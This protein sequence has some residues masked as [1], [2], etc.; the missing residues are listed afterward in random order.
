MQ[1]ST[2]LLQQ[3]RKEKIFTLMIEG[4]MSSLYSHE[5][6]MNQRINFTHFKQALQSKTSTRGRGGQQGGRSH[7]RGRGRGRHDNFNNKDED[8]DTNSFK[9]RGNTSRPKNKSHIQC[10]RCKKY[11]HYKLQC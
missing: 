5:E 9:G 8:S 3:L 7:G 10:F 2:L 4:L 11:G 6:R 1:D